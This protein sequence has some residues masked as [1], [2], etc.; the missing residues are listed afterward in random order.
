MT[1]DAISDARA[2]A[3]RGEF[4]SAIARLR[5]WAEAGNREAQYQL[6]F[7]ALTEGDLISGREAFWLFLTAAAQG[8]AE[9]MYHLATFPEFLS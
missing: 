1:Q 9:A 8:H 4:E 6:G 5:P 3:A 7:L 2:A